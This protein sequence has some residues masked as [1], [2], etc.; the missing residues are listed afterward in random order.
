MKPLNQITKQRSISQ[1]SESYY[2]RQEKGELNDF[3]EASYCSHAID[4]MKTNIDKID[5]SNIIF[6]MLN[7][8]VET[9]ASFLT[10]VSYFTY[11]TTS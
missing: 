7:A 3:E 1:N 10:W 8:S 9:T 5:L 11:T 4:R 2:E 6:V